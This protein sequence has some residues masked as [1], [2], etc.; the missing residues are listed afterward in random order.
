MEKVRI[1]II[2]AGN[3]GHCHADAY[4][5]MENVEITAVC[6]INVER[7]RQFAELYGIPNVYDSHLKLLE[8]K[9][10]DAASVCVWN[11][12]HARISIDVLNSGLHVLCEK[13]MALD[14]AQCLEMEEAAAANHRVLI[15][16]F[17]TRYEEGIQLLKKYIGE[18]RLGKIY[19]VNL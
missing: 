6:D 12:A 17:C 13:P 10:A 2:G 11:N 18:G 19:Y 9:T 1:A 7:A 8:A 4:R 3:I 16:G 5:K 15:P 14:T